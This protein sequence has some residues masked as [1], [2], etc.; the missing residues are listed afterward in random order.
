MWKVVAVGVV[1]M[2]A[3]G[4]LAPMA[5]PPPG[6]PAGDPSLVSPFPEGNGFDGLA[7]RLRSLPATS[8]PTGTGEV[9][10]R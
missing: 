6:P 1:V 3:M 7:A 10:T 8:V 5:V 4:L 2:G 9:A